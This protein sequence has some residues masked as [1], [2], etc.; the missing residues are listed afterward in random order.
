M[1]FLNSVFE[2]INSLSAGNQMIAGAISL[3]LSL[4]IE[5]KK[6]FLLQQQEQEGTAE[7]ASNAHG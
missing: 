5:L 2:F 4:K 7:G 3:W 6:M 1:S